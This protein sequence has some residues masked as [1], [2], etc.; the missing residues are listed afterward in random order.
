MSK[1]IIQIDGN[2]F[3]ASCEQLIDPS[4]KGKALVVL[5]NNDGCIIAR[6]S[7]ARKMGIPMGKPYFKLKN[8][9]NK[10]NINVRSS[11]Y[12]L[13]GD[14]SNRLMQLL[15]K[16]CEE[17]EIYSIDEAFGTISRP[18]DKCLYKWGRNL[19]TLVY[20][21]IGIPISIG[22]G[23]TKVLS[24]IS[25]HLAKIIQKNS[26]IFDIGIVE[27][28]DYYLKQVKV[29]KVWGVGKRMSTWLKDR[30][31]TNARE[32]RDMSGTKIEQKYGVAG[33]R[34]QNE[35]K[36][37]LCI[38]IK[39]ISSDKK[40]ICVSRS[41]GYPLDSL[42][43]LNQV[44]SSYVLIASAKLR[45]N[46]QLC[47]AIKIFMRTNIHSKDF[48]ESEG[49]EKLIIPNSDP[50]RIIKISL[51]LTR[52]IFKPYKKFTKAGVIFNQLQSNSYKQM[53]LFNKKDI[54]EELN[55][56][57]LINLIENIN[58]KN[59]KNI[60]GW[61]SSIIKKDWMPRKE[62]LSYLKTTTIENIPTVFAK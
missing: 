10:L 27:N 15:R 34:I 55:L 53:S 51:A 49:T 35:L 52:K 12:E 54:K 29:D 3:Y 39:E 20:Q 42:E 6:S 4:V 40:E 45:R 38:P 48:F 59:G 41:F 18:K 31:I 43:E 2:N 32:L 7:E 57:R 33:L 56:E 46:N 36:G 8:K 13:Y 50:K 24:K 30:G 23:E 17:I 25:N 21:N 60:L 19:R 5:S 44:I 47:S 16:H 11:N 62:K 22:I 58:N 61:G 14:I 37:K 26:G 28:K 9:L 1:A